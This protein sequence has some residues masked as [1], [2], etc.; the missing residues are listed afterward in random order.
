M[1][2]VLERRAERARATNRQVSDQTW[3]NDREKKLAAQ[4]QAASLA[5]QNRKSRAA[6]RICALGRGKLARLEAAELRAQHWAALVFQ[7]WTR[8][9]FGRKR[10]REARWKLLRVVPSLYALKLMRL[11]SREVDRVKDWIE[12][13]DPL[14]NSFWYFNKAESENGIPNTCWDHPKEFNDKLTCVW[15]P[16][17]Y[18]HKSETP[19]NQACC[20]RFKTRREYNT[21]RIKEHSWTCCGC[22]T[23]N[24]GLTYPRCW[25]C[26]NS[27]AWDGTDL[28]AKMKAEVTKTLF[29]FNHPELFEQDED[30]EDEDDRNEEDSLDDEESGFGLE[31]G[32]PALGPDA[33]MAKFEEE[34]K[35]KKEVERMKRERA[36]A[37]KSNLPQLAAYNPNSRQSMMISG[38]QFNQSTG[39]ATAMASDGDSAAWGQESGVLDPI[40]IVPTLKTDIAVVKSE[41][42]RGVRVDQYLTVCR[43]FKKGTCTKTTCPRAH[44]GLRDNAELFPVEGKGKRGAFMVQVCWDWIVRGKCNDGMHCTKYHSYIR[45]ETKEI[46]MRLY[47]KRNGTRQKESASGMLVS[48]SVSDEIFQGY[49]IIEW[50]SGDSYCGNLKDNLRSG[51]GV[52]KSA[53]GTKE[54]LGNWVRGLREGWGV[55]THPVG[56]TYVGEFVSGKMEGVGRLTSANGDIYDGNFINGKY[57][58]IGKFQKSNGDTFIGY[59]HEGDAEG[60]GVQVYAN[61]FKYKGYF[62]KNKRS[63][64]GVAIYPNKSKYSGQWSEGYHEGFGM[65]V[66]AD[67]ACYVGQWRRGKKHGLGRYYF[68]NGD[69]YD[70]HFMLDHA[71][72]H[73]VYFHK[74]TEN[75][76]VGQWEESKR[77]G[78]GTYYYKTGSVYKGYF[79]ENDIHGKGVFLFANGSKY[80]GQFKNNLKHGFGKFTWPNGNHYAGNFADDKMDGHGEMIYSSGHEYRG[81][82]KNNKKHGRG[83]FLSNRGNIYDGFFKNDIREG[84]GK[85]IYFPGTILEE[86]Y[87][88]DWVKGMRHGMGKYVYK[89]SEGT[90]YEGEW[91]KD[92]RHGKG[93]VRFKDGSVYSGDIKR[94]RIEGEG[95]WCYKDGN[96]YAG[97]FRNGEKSGYGTHLNGTS[98]EIFQGDFENGVRHGRGKLTQIS[99]NSF[100]GDFDHGVVRGRGTYELRCSEDDADVISLQVFGF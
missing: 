19:S 89:Q 16:V 78:I 84:K 10:A 42:N 55:L 36:R 17:T 37:G 38:E 33:A 21:H 46:I 68:Q 8:G 29:K 24:T 62:S 40:E 83:V 97:S 25:V 32:L 58:G 69:F 52:W 91:V 92:L 6:T 49:G 53:D 93:I 73:G 44:P 63:G 74:D 57:H 98:G 61:G 60:L 90:V 9:A 81:A 96:Q 12:M 65:F 35:A 64:K 71:A 76:Y 7:K 28:V 31:K 5:D 59:S 54:Y 18:P 4:L 22:E 67:N 50:T 14:T 23:I 77:C 3:I 13:F 87:D 20:M 2:V 27:R 34:K 86:M 72:G 99:G 85:Q 26:N 66:S 11:R 30:D 79:A 41:V 56:E 100:S 75:V 48:G 82:W 39:F 95:T 88:G 45:P 80:A 15:H 51:F 47:P 94:E 1:K 43:K 70:G